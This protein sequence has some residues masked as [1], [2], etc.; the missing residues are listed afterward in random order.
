[1]SRE[2]SGDTL[3]PADAF[4]LLGNELRMAILRA[5]W[6]ASDPLSTDDAVG[7]SELYR[8]VGA[9][10]SG[11]FNYHLEKLVGHF[12]QRSD[13]GYELTTAGEVIVQAVIAGSATRNPTIEATAVDDTC[14]VCGAPVQVAYEAGYL[15]VTCTDCEGFWAHEDGT[16][17]IGRMNLPPAGLAKWDVTELLDVSVAYLL[18]S[19]ELAFDGI[20]PVCTSPVEVTLDV[21]H[22]HHLADGSICAACDRHF[23]TQVTLVC[24]TCKDTFRAPYFGPLLI[25]PQTTAF[26]LDHGIEHFHNS[27]E[28]FHI[29]QSCSERILTDDPLTVELTL[30]IDD[31]E[32][33]A[34]LTEDG[35]LAFVDG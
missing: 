12:A 32:L 24:P 35:N 5:L 3:A 25:Q 19:A 31:E 20:C 6:E 15:M 1:M 34:H 26:L 29:G 17:I 30:T 27:S 23:M 10:D 9:D 7:F 2:G 14:I 13:D 21:C 22:E 18:R 4:S 28:T 8:L 16:G 33:V 11:K